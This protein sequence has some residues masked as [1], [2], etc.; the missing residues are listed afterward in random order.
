MLGFIIFKPSQS[1]EIPVY[2]TVNALNEFAIIFIALFI[3][4]DLMKLFISYAW[5]GQANADLASLLKSLAFFLL[6]SNYTPIMQSF[7]AFI[8]EVADKFSSKETLRKNREE[9]ILLYLKE[10]MDPELKKAADDYQQKKITKEELT[11]KIKEKTESNDKEGAILILSIKQFV[12]GFFESSIILICSLL[13]FIIEGIAYYVSYILILIGPL[14]IAFSL[15]PLGI[16]QNAIINWFTSWLSYKMWVFI[17]IIL[18]VFQDSFDSAG[19]ILA[20]FFGD[21]TTTAETLSTGLIIKSIMIVLYIMTPFFANLIVK[22]GASGMHA[23]MIG[24]TATLAMSAKQ[25]GTNLINKL[26]K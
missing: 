21:T 19:L 4:I 20:G 23:I 1:I 5:Q 14:V 16:N 18:D 8:Y 17:V 11:K 26:R 22:G 10:S 3:V 7:D 25:L 12:L 24:Q 2:S 13:R 15:L 9:I 6:L